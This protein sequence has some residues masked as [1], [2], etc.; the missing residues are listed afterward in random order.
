VRVSVSSGNP[1]KDDVVC[2]CWPLS[3]D[4]PK[5]PKDP[6]LPLGTVSHI[7]CR[8]ARIWDDA[9][10]NQRAS[11]RCWRVCAHSMERT[12][13]KCV[14]SAGTA[15]TQ[16]VPASGVLP[17]RNPRWRFGLAQIRSHR[18]PSQLSLEWL[19][20]LWGCSQATF[21]SSSPSTCSRLTFGKD[22]VIRVWETLTELRERLPSVALAPFADVCGTQ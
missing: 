15:R 10:Q 12:R 18:W 9:Q 13:R 3:G 16:A 20:A 11:R 2:F 22:V 17:T 5:D 14:R 1:P 19:R 7:Q 8:C 4:L 21:P 6:R